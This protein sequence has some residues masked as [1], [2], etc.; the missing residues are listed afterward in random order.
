MGSVQ[1]NAFVIM[2]NSQRELAKKSLPDL[3]EEPY[4]K[5][6]LRNDIIKLL[7]EMNCQWKSGEVPTYGNS[8]V[9][10]LTDTLWVIGGH[11]DVFQKQG[12]GLP[13]ML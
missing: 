12:F 2:M 13:F 7:L 5:L 4:N 9:Q 1:V 10:A 6:R 11:H 8:L 3:I